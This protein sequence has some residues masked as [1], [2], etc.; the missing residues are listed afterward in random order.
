MDIWWNDWPLASQEKKM[1]IKIQ[2]DLLHFE[3]LEDFQRK[4]LQQEYTFIP[5][6]S[7]YAVSR[8]PYAKLVK[9]CLFK[10]DTLPT[11]YLQEVL[12]KYPSIVIEDQRKK[13]VPITQQ[14]KLTAPTLRDYQIH[15]TTKLLGSER[16]LLLAPSGSGKTLMIAE[17]V[18]QLGMSTCIFV[19]NLTSQRQIFRC[20]KQYLKNT[21]IEKISGSTS[22]VTSAKVKILS[23]PSAK[24][25]DLES[26]ACI[27]VDETHHLAAPFYTEVVS[28]CKNAYFR[29]G[30]TGT[31]KGRSDGLERIIEG[32]ISPRVIEVPK[33]TIKD[34][35]CP[36]TFR[37]LQIQ[38]PSILAEEFL[39]I[40]RVGIVSNDTRNAMIAE[41][42]KVH[43]NDTCLV[44]VS[45]TEQGTLIQRYLPV[46]LLTHKTPVAER[47]R[48]I[49][50]WK[51][52]TY[53]TTNIFGESVDVPDINVII[54]AA[55]GKADI[56]I[57]QLVGRGLRPARD[58][59][60]L[61]VY[62]F[63][64]KGH[65]ILE[66]HSRRRINLYKKFG[67]VKIHE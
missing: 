66:K 49:K 40:Y 7:Y 59:T 8:N 20:L 14:K 11:G 57:Q 41:I 62:D 50:A 16:G 55:G 29:Y 26:F 15:S 22:K 43:K 3:G 6:G 47:M 53:I 9:I 32:M 63:F 61:I 12:D 56:G 19:T 28:K 42:A 60:K 45:W 24:K 37:V 52:K 48:Y 23:V 18:R 54:N 35:L 65:F 13:V 2:N 46:P 44:Y 25:V 51:G 27:I 10:K 58:K 34:Y 67:E 1:K 64:D 21:T 30:F 36:V 38:T 31:L 17:V 39:D 4:E 5:K 33:D